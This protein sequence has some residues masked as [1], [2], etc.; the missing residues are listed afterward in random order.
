MTFWD[1]LDEL[2]RTI[3]RVLIVTVVASVAAFLFKDELFGVVLAPKS[4][5]FVTYRLLSRLTSLM[6]GEM[7]DFSVQ[8]IN[9][10][11]AQQ[12]ITHMKVAFCAGI[13]CA[14]PYMVYKIFE[15]VSPALYEKERKFAYP[16]VTAGYLLF[17]MGMLLSYFLIFPLTFRF[18]GTYQVSGVVENLISLESYISTLLM[19]CLMM[20]VMF[21]IPVVSWLLAKF[22]IIDASWMVS[23]RRHAFVV[24][25]VLSAIITPTSDVFTLLVVALPIVLLYEVS[26]FV[27]KTTI[28]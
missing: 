7:E 28:R 17:V 8:L 14:S 6:G 4:A 15:F 16:V 20:G 18:L 25:L 13:L 24:V 3:I 2:R 12:F 27:V 9:T 26:I 23:H 1:H 10:G 11:L 19:L 5:D 21:E 22:G